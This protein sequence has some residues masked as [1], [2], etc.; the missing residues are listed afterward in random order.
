ML[1]IMWINNIKWTKDSDKKMKAEKNA[2][3]QRE[4]S[5]WANGMFIM[6]LFIWLSG[7]QSGK[8]ICKKRKKA[9]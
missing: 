2:A 9:H 7:L 6:I 1:F 3:K 8:L 5:A 4:Q